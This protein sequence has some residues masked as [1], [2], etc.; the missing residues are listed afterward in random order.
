MKAQAL[1]YI[2]VLRP[3]ILLAF[4]LIFN[5]AAQPLPTNEAYDRGTGQLDD[6][7]GYNPPNPGFL[8]GNISL[9]HSQNPQLT[10]EYNQPHPF[11]N[12]LKKFGQ[13]GSFPKYYQQLIAT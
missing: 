11:P 10:A 8:R 7:S 2:R 9:F 3:G 12:Y 4:Y 13:E 1:P 5:L 6:L